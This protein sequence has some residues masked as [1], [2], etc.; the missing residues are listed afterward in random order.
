M[1]RYGKKTNYPFLALKLPASHH[2]RVAHAS[3]RFIPS[4]FCSTTSLLFYIRVPPAE[5][6]GV[7][8]QVGSRLKQGIIVLQIEMV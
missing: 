3:G 7:G 4:I 2:W 5:M 1:M 6:L 8:T